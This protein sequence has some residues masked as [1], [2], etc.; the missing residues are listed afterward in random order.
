VLAMPVQPQNAM[1]ACVKRIA[2]R[3][4]GVIPSP[5]REDTGH[6]VGADR[7]D[8]LRYYRAYPLWL[9]DISPMRRKE[10]PILGDIR[11]RYRTASALTCLGNQAIFFCAGNCS[12]ASDASGGKDRSGVDAT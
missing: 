9:D 12:F 11:H 5:R 3:A 4:P 1:M 8:Q 10:P 6:Q 7:V 2:R